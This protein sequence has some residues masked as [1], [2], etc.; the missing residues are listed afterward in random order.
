MYVLVNPNNLKS[1]TSNQKE[2]IDSYYSYVALIEATVREMANIWR[3]ADYNQ[4][5]EKMEVFIQDLKKVGE[6]M[7]SYSA[8]IDSYSGA[9]ALLD[10]EYGSKKINLK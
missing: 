2:Y 5:A 9:V 7:E 4:F 6:S 8:F 10:S 1:Q 3:G